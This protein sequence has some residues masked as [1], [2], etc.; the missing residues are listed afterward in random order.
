MLGQVRLM[1]RHVSCIFAAACSVWLALSDFKVVTIRRSESAHL[2][3]A[4]SL[5]RPGDNQS[6]IAGELEAGQACPC[7]LRS[8]INHLSRSDQQ[9]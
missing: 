3:P 9:K 8:R 2:I 5:Y 6:I 1:F 4:Q 7:Q